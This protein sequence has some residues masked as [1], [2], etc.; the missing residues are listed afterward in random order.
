LLSLA[1]SEDLYLQGHFQGV[2]P[3]KCNHDRYL[4]EDIIEYGR[5]SRFGLEAGSKPEL[6]IAIANLRENDDALLICN[7]YKVSDL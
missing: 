3:V 7:G 2:F 5:K 4:I 1:D 6:L